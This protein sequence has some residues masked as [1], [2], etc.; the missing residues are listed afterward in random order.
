MK[1]RRAS[2]F[3][4]LVVLGLVVYAT[5]TLMNLHGQIEQARSDQAALQR[6]VVEQALENSIYEYEIERSDDPQMIERIARSRYNLVMP[7][8][9]TF[10]GIIN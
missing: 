7:G 4:K 9:R 1:S 10:Y 2:I 6:A 8:E 5:I 3:T